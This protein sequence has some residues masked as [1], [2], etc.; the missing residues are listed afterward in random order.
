LASI[1][2][3][4]DLVDLVLEDVGLEVLHDT[5]FAESMSTLFENDGR[6]GPVSF[7]CEYFV[8][9]ADFALCF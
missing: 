9:V 4:A 3:T 5:L 7:V 2:W 6:C 8:G 1:L